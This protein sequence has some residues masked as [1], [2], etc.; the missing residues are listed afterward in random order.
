MNE[1]SLVRRFQVWETKLNQMGYKVSVT[2]NGFYIH[3]SKGT[4]VADILT[5][6]GIRGF[7]QAIEWSNETEN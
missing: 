4:I 7:A 2:D 3:N 1:C 6:D 5:V